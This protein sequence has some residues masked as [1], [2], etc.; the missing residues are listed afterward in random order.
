MHVHV[1]APGQNLLRLSHAG[2]KSSSWRF[3]IGTNQLRETTLTENIGPPEMLGVERGADNS[4]LEKLS[5]KLKKQQLA[6]V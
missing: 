4:N 3:Q 6:S 5:R 1:V 2:R